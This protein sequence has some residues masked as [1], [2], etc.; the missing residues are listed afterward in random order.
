MSGV[1]HGATTYQCIRCLTSKQIIRDFKVR[2]TRTAH[3]MVEVFKLYK[4]QYAV[5]FKLQGKAEQ[6]EARAKLDELVFTLDLYSLNGN[7]G[8][9][10]LQGL[11]N[12]EWWNERFPVFTV[13]RLHVL[14][15][16]ISKYPRDYKKG[17]SSVTDQEVLPVQINECRK[18]ASF[19][20]S[21]LMNECNDFFLSIRISL[22][23]QGLT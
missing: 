1:K 19:C 9:L 4:H 5:Y 20:K 22:P 21:Q 10:S 3:E 23:C 18:T 7:G 12:F 11:T 17:L 8:V 16:G 15:L 2:T 14:H 13:A 6:R